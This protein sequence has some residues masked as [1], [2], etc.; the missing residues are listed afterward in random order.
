M[1]QFNFNRSGQPTLRKFEVFIIVEGRNIQELMLNEYKRRDELIRRD[2]IR[3][4][5]SAKMWESETDI[6]DQTINDLLNGD[7]T[8]VSQ[9]NLS[10][11]LAYFQKHH[12]NKEGRKMLLTALNLWGDD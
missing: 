3:K 11:L 4:G 2:N 7:K 8:T 1:S 12:G 10:R 9:E 6:N 5:F